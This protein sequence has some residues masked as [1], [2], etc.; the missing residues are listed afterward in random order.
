MITWGRC[1]AY[2]NITE[3]KAERKKWVLETIGGPWLISWRQK[4]D[5]HFQASSMTA[6][7]TAKP[8]VPGDHSGAQVSG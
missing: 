2:T 7:L 6:G 4:R 1:G 5:T 3:A 8:R